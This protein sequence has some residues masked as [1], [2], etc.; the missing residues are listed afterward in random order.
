MTASHR[1]PPLREGLCPSCRH[2]RVVTS[3]RGS[4]F[5]RCGLAGK[6]PRLPKYPPQPVVA[7]PGHEPAEPGEA[8]S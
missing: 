6:D 5:L 4:R 3:A 7:C 1:I 2:V 8:R